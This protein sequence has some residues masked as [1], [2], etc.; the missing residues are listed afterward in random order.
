MF[1]EPILSRAIFAVGV[2]FGLFAG[3]AF[4]GDVTVRDAWTRASA[5]GQTVA[6]VYFDIASVADA[7]LV[8][9][10]TDLTEAAEIHRMSMEDGVM[11]MRAVGSVTL[12]AGQTVKFRPGGYHVMLFDLPRPLQAGEQISV[13]LLVEDEAGERS[14]LT[15]KVDVRNLDG[16]KVQHHHH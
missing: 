8:A 1:V 5:P 14:T 9:V 7:R 13:D 4:A 16:S 2:F 3:V 10:Q 12:P 6:G 11:R 15:V